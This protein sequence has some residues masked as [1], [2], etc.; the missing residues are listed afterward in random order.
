MMQ[1]SEKWLPTSERLHRKSKAS[2][3]Q[4]VVL[5]QERLTN[6]TRISPAYRTLDKYT[7]LDLHHVSLTFQQSLWFLF[8]REKRELIMLILAMNIQ[9]NKYKTYN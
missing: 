2:S 8:L 6:D 4:S 1:K 9:N 3:L 7:G 5:D